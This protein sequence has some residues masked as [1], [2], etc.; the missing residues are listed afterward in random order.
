MLPQI[1][2]ALT[3]NFTGKI[4][5]KN[6]YLLNMYNLIEIALIEAVYEGKYKV[7]LYYDLWEIK[8]IK[9]VGMDL[10]SNKNDMNA[11]LTIHSKMLQSH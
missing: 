7:P 11:N 9:F 10:R 8:S 3:G 2:L 5:I 4:I 1:K 6:V